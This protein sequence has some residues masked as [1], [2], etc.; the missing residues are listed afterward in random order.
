VVANVDND[1]D[2]GAFLELVD[3]M[4]GRWPR[5]ISSRPVKNATSC[6]KFWGRLLYGEQVEVQIGGLAGKESPLY[7]ASAVNGSRLT[8]GA[9]THYSRPR[10]TFDSPQHL[11]YDRCL[12]CGSFP[13][14]LPYR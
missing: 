4:A 13:K 9:Q 2:A 8:F 3:R 11:V 10:R 12:G 5:P 1:L 14:R 6:I 7:V